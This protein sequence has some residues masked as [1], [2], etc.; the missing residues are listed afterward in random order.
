MLQQNS[1][2]AADVGSGTQGRQPEV[3]L[4]GLRV[5]LDLPSGC[6][7]FSNTVRV[8][9]TATPLTFPPLRPGALCSLLVHLMPH[10]L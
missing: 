7:L 10:V 8:V 5:L 1:P 3:K 4:T 6:R 2:E 9:L